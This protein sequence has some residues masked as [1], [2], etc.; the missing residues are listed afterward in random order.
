MI[1]TFNLK[2]CSVE[3]IISQ[4]AVKTQKKAGVETLML[5]NKGTSS[6]QSLS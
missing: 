4:I 2:M 6:S 5:I 1:K 3:I